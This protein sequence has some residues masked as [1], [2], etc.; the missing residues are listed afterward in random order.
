[1]IESFPVQKPDS[2]ETTNTI[3]AAHDSE[4]DSVPEY[5]NIQAYKAERKKIAES[6]RQEYVERIADEMQSTLAAI[7]GLQNDAHT[8]LAKDVVSSTIRAPHVRIPSV[9]PT[10]KNFFPFLAGSLTAS[11]ESLKGQI[12]FKEEEVTVGNYKHAAEDVRTIHENLSAIRRTAN[13]LFS[14]LETTNRVFDAFN[15]ENITEAN[16]EADIPFDRDALL[17]SSAAVKAI[18][19]RAVRLDI[20]VEGFQEYLYKN[21][22]HG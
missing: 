20:D 13:Q 15:A 14:T 7:R 18:A 6:I 10:S 3:L 22:V 17:A 2:K 5:E 11:L 12:S 1:M 19:E 9:P 4:F 21:E 8:F 16:T